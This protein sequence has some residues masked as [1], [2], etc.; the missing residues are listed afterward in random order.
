[1][2]CTAYVFSV[3]SFLSYAWVLPS[4]ER[5]IWSL[6]DFLHSSTV[7][8]FFFWKKTDETLLFKVMMTESVEEVSCTWR[9]LSSVDR[10]YAESG[11]LVSWNWITL[12]LLI[13]IHLHSDCRK[14]KMSNLD[15]LTL[16]KPLAI[17]KASPVKC[18]SFQFCQWPIQ[19]W[20]HG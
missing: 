19:W 2:Y 5:F 15:W 4:L 9:D 8:F 7:L 10:F 16:K 6:S 17:K 18:L 14:E 20:L 11:V 3:I 13:N 1:M 12:L